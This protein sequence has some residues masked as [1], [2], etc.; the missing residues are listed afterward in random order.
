MNEIVLVGQFHC[1]RRRLSWTLI[2]A[3]RISPCTERLWIR[4]R[5][6]SV[7]L[8]RGHLA[9]VRE[10]ASPFPSPHTMNGIQRSIE[11]NEGNFSNEAHYL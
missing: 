9:T 3:C 1:C 7:F 11:E 5:S 8:R 6:V 4:L 2:M 10:S